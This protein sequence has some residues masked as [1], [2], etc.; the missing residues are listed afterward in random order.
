MR[1]SRNFCQGE[2]GGSRPD[3][4]KTVLTCFLVLNLLYSFYSGCPM[5]ILKKTIIFYGFRGGGGQHLPGG[6]TFS[7]G[8]GGGPDANFYRNPYNL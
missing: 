4:Q 1:G 3:C 7:R 6:P 5:V 8:G 2:G